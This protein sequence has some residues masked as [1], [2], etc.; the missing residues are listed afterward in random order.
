M[1]VFIYLLNSF[2][3][4]ISLMNESLNVKSTCTFVSLLF[5]K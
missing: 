1:S 4:V 2:A 3:V 5:T